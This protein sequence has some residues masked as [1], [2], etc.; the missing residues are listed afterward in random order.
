MAEDDIEASDTFLSTC[1]YFFIIV[2]ALALIRRYFKGAQFTEKASAKNLVI[3]VTGANCGIG[4]E[5]VRELNLRKG[6]VYMLCRNEDRANEA[7][8]NLVKLGCHSFRLHII[9]CDLCNFESIRNAAKELLEAEDH[10]D[11][12]INNAG[13]MFQNK[14]ETT[15]DGH[16]KT[17]QSNHLGHFLLTELLL[18]AIKKSNSGRIVN[19]SSLLHTHSKRIDLSKVDDKKY[20]G[21]MSSYCQSKLANVMH[22][23]ALTHRLRK[24]GTH[25]VTVNSLHP[26]GVNTP[27]M[28][29]SFFYLPVIK[30]I[31]AP[32]R[33][34]VLK[35]PRDGAQTSLYCALSK[36]V[37]G[38]SGKYFKE[39]KLA[40]ESPLAT[41]D[42]ACEDLYNYSLEQ[43]GLSK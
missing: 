40:A 13:I 14:F 21:S 20:F 32:F 16:E 26:G 38:V 6:K 33:W 29:S 18:P 11:I 10:I 35:T 5:T 4:F 31:T 17:W 42:Q 34:F 41:D 12:L 19:V 15:I 36:K 2:G 39:C 22:A 7:R 28:R 8:R 9:E 27:L 1:L 43:T 24:E 30:Q 25:N 37:E 3:V 23:R